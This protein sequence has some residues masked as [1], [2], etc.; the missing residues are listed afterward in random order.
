MAE[1]C[2]VKVFSTIVQDLANRDTQLMIDSTKEMEVYA[3]GS[4]SVWYV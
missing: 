1:Q 2:H 3:F 4:V